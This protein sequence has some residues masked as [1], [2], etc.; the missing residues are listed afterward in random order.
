MATRVA[1][2]GLYRSGSTPTAGVLHH[3]GVNMGPPYWHDCYEPDDL[4]RRLRVWWNEPRRNLTPSR[5]ERK[6]AQLRGES[7]VWLNEPRLKE[8]AP[9]TERVAELLRWIENHEQAR[10]PCTGAKQ[11]LLCLSGQDL[12]EAWGSSMRF[13]WTHRPL[14]KSVRSLE[15][16]NW[17]P[18]KEEEMQ[19][20]LWR[21]VTEFFQHQPHLRVDFSAMMED[22]TR[23]IGRI[24]DYLGLQ[25]DP[26]QIAAATGY[27]S[28]KNRQ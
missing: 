5:G 18:G 12:L 11:P 13:I 17:F 19:G 10:A 20:T 26:R 15:S 1:V 27:I 23:E 14:E 9:A 2:L 3:L 4:S 7:A 25:P 6:D 22:P 24:I 8:S 28:P 21:A 16:L